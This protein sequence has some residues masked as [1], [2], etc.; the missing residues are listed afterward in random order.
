MTRKKL[1]DQ[2][3]GQV[4]ALR[5]RPHHF[6]CSLGFEGKGYSDAFTANMTAIVMGQLRA[7]GGADTVIEVV[8]QTDD[9]CQPCPKRRGSKCTSQAR[10][11]ALDRRHAKALNL[12]TGDRLTWG[13]ASARIREHVKPDDLQT[14]CAGCQWLDLGL[15]QAAVK[16]LHRQD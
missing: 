8:G 3:T 4:P 15:C 14:I 13:Q 16:R 11:E 9:I 5:F 1:Q 2:G 6:L 12:Q 10:I 7:S